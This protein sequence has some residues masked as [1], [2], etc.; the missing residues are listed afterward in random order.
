MILRFL[1][2]LVMFPWCL[3]ELTRSH[4]SFVETV[5]LRHLTSTPPSQRQVDNLNLLLQI[6]AGGEVRTMYS[7][8]L[9]T[10]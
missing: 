8:V 10:N 9:A 1:E 7:L 5:N 2:G 4:K 6:Y 3:P